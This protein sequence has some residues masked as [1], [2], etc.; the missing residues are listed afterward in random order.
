MPTLIEQHNRSTGRVSVESLF[1]VAREGTALARAL[2]DRGWPARSGWKRTDEHGE[3]IWY[4]RF[5]RPARAAFVDG[6]ACVEITGSCDD[7]TRPLV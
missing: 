3:T 5:E 1:L 2:R 6:G 4:V 7:W